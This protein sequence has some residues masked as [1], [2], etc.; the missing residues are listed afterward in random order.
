DKGSP[1]GVAVGFASV[2]KTI[3]AAPTLTLRQGGTATVRTARGWTIVPDDGPSG[4]VIKVP[5]PGV[6][7][8]KSVSRKQAQEQLTILA[9]ELQ[10][11]R[12]ADL[13]ELLFDSGIALL[14]MA[15]LSVFL[16]W[17]VAGRALRPLRVITS[18]AQEISSASLHERIALRGPDDEMKRLG[19]TFDDLLARLERAFDAQRQFVANASHEL[20]TPL[21]RQRTMLEVASEDPDADVASLREASSKAVAAGEEQEQLIEA[22]LTLASSERGLDHRSPFDLAEV[23]RQVVDSKRS[24]ATLRALEL[25]S[26]LSDAPTTGNRRLTERLAANLVENALQYNE[27]GGWVEVATGVDAGH[28]V[29]RVANSGPVV[30]EDEIERLF[31]PFQRLVSDRTSREG[32]GLGLSIVRAVANAHGATV[33]ATSRLTGGLDL[34]V[35]FLLEPEADVKGTATGTATSSP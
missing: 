28:A 12:N 4:L 8:G 10:S 6:A 32:H 27:P 15:A 22:L 14:I 24:E 19:D 29:L 13:Q 2:P 1:G 16:G 31:E 20:R 30:P 5:V 9:S 34:R 33:T 7:P 26:E 3:A 25:M 18:K 21:A 11:G 17:L 23:V 35:A